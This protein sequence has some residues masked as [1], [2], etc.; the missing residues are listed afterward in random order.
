MNILYALLSETLRIFADTRNLSQIDQII[1]YICHLLNSPRISK[2]IIRVHLSILDLF[3]FLHIYICVQTKPFHFPCI[4][5]I[6]LSWIN[7][8][9]Q[10]VYFS[11]NSHVTILFRFV[12]MNI[13][14]TH[15]FLFQM[16]D[17]YHDF[18]PNR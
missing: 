13:M 11:W 12:Y 4:A 7:D 5:K 18:I 15:H 8:S 9:R 2:C 16:T 14:H 6:I 10:D 1:T 3:V 17:S